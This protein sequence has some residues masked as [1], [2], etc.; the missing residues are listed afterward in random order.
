M[1]FDSL[2]Y[3]LL[4]CHLD[5]HVEAGMAVLLKVGNY[6][7]FTR[8]PEN[9]P[10]CGNFYNA[11]AQKPTQKPTPSHDLS[12]SDGNATIE[13]STVSS[14]ITSAEDSVSNALTDFWKAVKNTFSKNGSSSSYSGS[15]SYF[16]FI[17]LCVLRFV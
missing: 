15:S 4:H 14:I 7:D 10:R 1:L 11:D 17:I 3:W 8:P 2:G 5:F 9:F 12:S 13:S 6:S 16:M